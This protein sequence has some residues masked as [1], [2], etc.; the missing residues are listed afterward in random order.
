MQQA[1]SRESHADPLDIELVPVPDSVMHLQTHEFSVYCKHAV[2][3]IS[4]I[5]VMCV[6]LSAYVT[7]AA[8]FA[9]CWFCSRAVSSKC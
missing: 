4:A 9:A 5:F 7:R 2:F 6:V 8:M 3:V 1:A